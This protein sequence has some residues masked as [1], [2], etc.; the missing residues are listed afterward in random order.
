MREVVDALGCANP[1]AML[2]AGMIAGMLDRRDEARQYLL[3]AAEAYVND[4]EMKEKALE[5]VTEILH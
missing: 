5:F 1:D 4:P 2:R 3:R